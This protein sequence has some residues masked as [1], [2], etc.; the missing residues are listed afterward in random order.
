MGSYYQ[1]YLGRPADNGGLAVFVTALQQGATDQQ[2]IADIV[3]SPE[4]WG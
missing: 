2:V 3:G 1:T 4:Y